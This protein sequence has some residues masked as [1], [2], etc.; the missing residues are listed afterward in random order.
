MPSGS[1]RA[2]TPSWFRF[3][4]YQVAPPLRQEY[5][6]HFG[7]EIGDSQLAPRAACDKVIAAFDSAE[8]LVHDNQTTTVNGRSCSCIQ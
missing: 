8:G 2:S 7:S 6:A 1:I 5:C 4:Q 3:P